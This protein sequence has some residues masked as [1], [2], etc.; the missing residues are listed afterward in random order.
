MASTEIRR[1]RQTSQNPTCLRRPHGVQAVGLGRTS[2]FVLGRLGGRACFSAR[3]CFFFEL[4]NAVLHRRRLSSNRHPIPSNR[5]PIPS[6]RHP[7]PSN[8]RRLAPNTEGLCTALTESHTR[9]TALW[10]G[11]HLM[12]L[13]TGSDPQANQSALRRPDGL[14]NR[15]SSP[16][17]LFSGDCL[18]GGPRETGAG[19]A[20]TPPSA[21]APAMTAPDVP[22]A[23]PPQNGQRDRAHGTDKGQRSE[24]RRRR[25][26]QTAIHCRRRAMPPSPP[27]PR[28]RVRPA[29]AAT[30]PGRPLGSEVQPVRGSRT[31]A[32]PSEPPP[33]RPAAPLPAQQVAQDDDKGERV[34]RRCP[35]QVTPSCSQG[36]VPGG[37]LGPGGTRVA[38][39]EGGPRLNG[40]RAEP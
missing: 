21:S 33:P 7:I 8:R 36:G 22:P 2:D 9:L 29:T 24:A 23:S 11:L 20:R 10:M 12:A 32:I 5:H 37:A 14:H 15:P 17:L 13:G 18:S 30:R 19:P 6:N 27:P 39:H 26:L 3:E 40:P 4:T 35:A 25:P 31:T 38:Q 1:D 16:P 34:P 28:L